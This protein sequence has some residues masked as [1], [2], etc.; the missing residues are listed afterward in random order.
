[1]AWVTYADGGLPGC[2]VLF[3]CSTGEPYDGLVAGLAV[4]FLVLTYIGVGLAAPIVLFLR[5]LGFR[6]R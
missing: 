3:E 1:M 6:Q 2:Y 5:L 4:S